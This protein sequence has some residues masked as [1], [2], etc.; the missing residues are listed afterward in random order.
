MGLPK[1]DQPIFELKLPSTGE[2]VKY[3]PFTVKEEKV[4]LIAKESGEVGSM[5]AAIEQVIGNCIVSNTVDIS[6]MATFDLEYIMLNIRAKSVNDIV[7]FSIKDPDTEEE[8][9]LQFNINDIQIVKD[10]SHTKDITISDKYKMRLRYPTT[11]E[12]FMLSDIDE[13]SSEDVTL[14]IMISCIEMLYDEDT[15]YNLSEFSK[16]EVDEFVESLPSNAI[17]DIRKFFNTIPKMK[18]V[19]PYKNKNGDTK[20]FV[21]EGTETF[22]I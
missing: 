22:F 2:K 11:K 14:N 10:D 1:I 15:V 17:Q 8:V 16:K 5:L 7:Q 19:C 4:L 18:V 20:S 3:R 12:L 21:I 6:K 9:P 13:K